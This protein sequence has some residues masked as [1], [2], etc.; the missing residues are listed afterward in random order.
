M[1]IGRVVVVVV[2]VV[3]VGSRLQ[4]SFPIWQDPGSRP[5][6]TPEDLPGTEE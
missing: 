3:V 6:V 1:T 5:L 2:V 4:D